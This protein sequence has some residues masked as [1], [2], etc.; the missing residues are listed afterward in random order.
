[1][2]EVV[3]L[4]RRK[5]S[6]EAASQYRSPLRKKRAVAPR[7]VDASELPL[8]LAFMLHRERAREAPVSP[9]SRLPSNRRD[10]VAASSQDMEALQRQ[11][12][13]LRAEND[14]L[15]K[16]GAA[17]AAQLSQANA[18]LSQMRVQLS[19]AN[20]A[21]HRIT[22][23]RSPATPR[24]VATPPH[25]DA[26]IRAEWDDAAA[27]IQ[28]QYTRWRHMQ[29]MR[30]LMDANK[31]EMANLAATLADRN[32]QLQA[33]SSRVKILEA[34]NAQLV[35]QGETQISTIERLEDE[36]RALQDWQRSQ[37]E[38]V[39]DQQTMHEVEVDGLREEHAEELAAL[40]TLHD[41]QLAALRAL[42]DETAS[43]HASAV[44]SLRSELGAAAQQSL[45]AASSHDQQVRD[46]RDEMQEQVRDLRDEMQEQARESR[47]AAQ[48]QEDEMQEQARESRVAAQNQAL[49]LEGVTL[50]AQNLR[51]QLADALRKHEEAEA[52]HAAETFA[53]QASFAHLQSEH[54][55]LRTLAEAHRD[56][57]EKLEI[58]L[59][60]TKRAH[61]ATH[62]Q[63]EYQRM[64]AQQDARQLQKKQRL[65]FE[66]LAEQHELLSNEHAAA[67]QHI[68]H[69]ASAAIQLQ[70]HRQQAQHDMRNL[71]AAHRAQVANLDATIAS[72]RQEVERLHIAHRDSLSELRTEHDEYVARLRDEHEQAMSQKLEEMRSQHTLALDEVAC[73]A[74]AT[75]AGLN[76]QIQ[77]AAEEHKRA[78]ETA[79]KHY[80]VVRNELR[81][82]E[83]QS[84]KWKELAS[85]QS[86]RAQPP[87]HDV[88]GAAA[89]TNGDAGVFKDCEEAVPPQLQP[90]PQRSLEENTPRRND[91]AEAVVA[92]SKARLENMPD[93]LSARAKVIFRR[94]DADGDGFLNLRELREMIAETEP[95]H[96]M[97]QGEYENMC[98]TLGCEQASGVSFDRFVRM[99]QP[100]LAA[101]LGCEITKDF[102]IVAGTWI[103]EMY[104]NDEDGFLSFEEAKQLQMDTVPDAAEISFSQFERLCTMLGCTASEGI[105]I[106]T[107]VMAYCPPLCHQ[108]GWD[109][110]AD[111]SLV[112][113]L[114]IAYQYDT[115]ALGIVVPGTGTATNHLGAE[116]GMA[117][118]QQL[119]S[120]LEG[121]Q[122]QIT[123]ALMQRDA[124]VRE[125]DAAARAAKAAEQ[126]ALM[127]EEEMDAWV[128]VAQ[129]IGG[130][131]PEVGNSTRN[132]VAT[133]VNLAGGVVASAE[134][135]RSEVQE[136]RTKL[137]IVE[138]ERNALERALETAGRNVEST[139]VFEAVDAMQ[140]A[141]MAAIRCRESMAELQQVVDEKD[142]AIDSHRQARQRLEEEMAAILSD[143]TRQALAVEKLDADYR[144]ALAAKQNVAELEIKQAK[145][146]LTRQ[147]Q[148]VRDGAK[149]ALDVLAATTQPH[150]QPLAVSS[151]KIEVGT[152][153]IATTSPSV[154]PLPF[155]MPRLPNSPPIT[156][157]T[158]SSDADAQHVRSLQLQDE[159]EISTSAQKQQQPQ[160]PDGAGDGELRRSTTTARKR[161]DDGRA[162][163]AS[164]L[165]ED[166]R[167]QTLKSEPGFA[168]N[169][170]S[171]MQLPQPVVATASHVTP[172]ATD[173]RR[174]S[175]PALPGFM[176]ATFPQLVGPLGLSWQEMA[177]PADF[178]SDPSHPLNGRDIKDRSVAVICALKP[179][180]SASHAPQIYPGLG[181]A[182]IEG[183]EPGS[184]GY[185]EVDMFGLG[186]KAAVAAIRTSPRPITMVLFAT[187]GMRLSPMRPSGFPVLSAAGRLPVG[188]SDSTSAAASPASSTRDVT[189]TEPG[190]LG[191]RHHFLPFIHTPIQNSRLRMP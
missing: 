174:R 121:T 138:S 50:E 87:Q 126:D 101:Q 45:E 123:E 75:I 41:E 182:A 158:N 180:M 81:E 38:F 148:G 177:L 48:S 83:E 100:P 117:R 145:A 61:A 90:Q 115:D 92:A 99:Y 71:L 12:A 7:T 42:H 147:A 30:A 134:A 106:D 94:Y 98:E 108:L 150:Q 18:Q 155:N 62:I 57:T 166:D 186:F 44:Q 28:S 110:A 133:A 143:L 175:L 13:E 183:G 16:N 69:N 51:T 151:L 56:E 55:Q 2:P 35:G 43:T 49:V 118:I 11:I 37:H 154:S 107:F 52:A 102:A 179:G 156:V 9:P 6:G 163:I 93:V 162:P 36:L 165:H 8:I 26:S 146:E 40:S 113:G 185:K 65:K 10:E 82:L 135:I 70:F 1:M 103:F 88:R 47:V 159:L 188:S 86:I 19:E 78:L 191:A 153:D 89:D 190:A 77:R 22:A 58:S 142:R 176:R 25:H 178:D 21:V 59:E 114:M 54:D 152:G 63:M 131:S 53:H 4:L 34:S 96:Y 172:M 168:P 97:S 85:T 169:E 67:Q 130:S 109:I 171:T 119:E 66:Q 84:S 157:G 68:H 31:R 3:R 95:G 20:L 170:S 173:S 105:N 116:A 137:D 91:P 127:T 72:L 60:S 79:A 29:D 120:E 32:S 144:K 39:A 5:A 124:A 132:Q 136:L 122:Q 140:K 80:D 149:A 141:Q 181:L 27:K 184:F 125:R 161:A 15:T 129:S 187:E 46:L 76:R 23:P 112:A 14:G 73:E 167:E 24:S 74:D 128:A 139:A 189:I 33:Y 17:L 111:F 160:Q 164:P 104:D 64:R